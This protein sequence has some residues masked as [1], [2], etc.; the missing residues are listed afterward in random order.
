MCQGARQASDQKQAP[1][2][3]HAEALCLC[4]KAL[5][6]KVLGLGFRV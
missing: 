6:F 3:L 5:K 2:A 1:V 4:A